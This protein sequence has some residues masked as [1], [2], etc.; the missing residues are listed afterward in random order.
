MRRELLNRGL[1][2]RTLEHTHIAVNKGALEVGGAQQ[3]CGEDP[4]RFVGARS[5][6]DAVWQQYS[7]RRKPKEMTVG[8]TTVTCR[9][10]A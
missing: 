8:G 10:A 5:G 2:T 1:N 6:R 3:L 4:L 9:G 7:T